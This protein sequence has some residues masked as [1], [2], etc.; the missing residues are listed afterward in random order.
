MFACVLQPGECL[1]A[2]GGDVYAGKESEIKGGEI[3][4]KAFNEA[5]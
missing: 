2:A 5:V 3:N 4:I 1:L